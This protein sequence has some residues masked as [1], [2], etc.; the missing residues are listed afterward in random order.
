MKA[1]LRIFPCQAGVETLL[2]WSGLPVL[3]FQ[4]TLEFSNSQ[5]S[6][7]TADRHFMQLQLPLSILPLSRFNLRLRLHYSICS[8][9]L[10]PLYVILI[11]LCS[12]EFQAKAMYKYNPG[13]SQLCP[14]LLR[15]LCPVISS[16][17]SCS[18]STAMWIQY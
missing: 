6:W 14:A 7:P 5:F 13:L 16:F 1:S 18:E 8:T 17:S 11:C 9:A 3:V 12:V 10:L 2:F 4:T 15:Q